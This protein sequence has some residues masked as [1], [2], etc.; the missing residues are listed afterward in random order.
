VE[1][2]VVGQTKDDQTGGA[3]PGITTAVAQGAWKMRGT[4]RFDDETSILAEEVDDERS[5]GV[6]AAE[7]GVHDLPAA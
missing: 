5:D 3:K 6:L 7:L 4:I 2:Q 1:D